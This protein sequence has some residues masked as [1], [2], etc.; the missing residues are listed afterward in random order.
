MTNPIGNKSRLFATINN[1]TVTIVKGDWLVLKLEYYLSTPG[2]EQMS[3]L[4]GYEYA[5]DYDFENYCYKAVC[6]AEEKNKRDDL[7]AA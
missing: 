3:M 4:E 5:F 6:I 2:N 7:Y 1:K